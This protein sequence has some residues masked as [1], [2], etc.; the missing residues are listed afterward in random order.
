MKLFQEFSHASI[1]HVHDACRAK[2][3]R[4]F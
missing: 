4:K 1:F 3:S 2:I